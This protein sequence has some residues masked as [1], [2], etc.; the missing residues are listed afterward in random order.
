LLLF[1][2]VCAECRQSVVTDRSSRAES[3][4]IVPSPRK[5]DTYYGRELSTI[6][7]GET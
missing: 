1:C 5:H 4:N 7:T 3:V 6:Y 2:W